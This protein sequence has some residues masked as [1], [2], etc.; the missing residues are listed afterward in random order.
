MN[1]TGRWWLKWGTGLAIAVLCSVTSLYLAVSSE[2]IAYRLYARIMM[3]LG[4]WRGNL[5]DDILP[6]PL[7]D[8]ARVLWVGVTLIGFILVL[9]LI[10]RAVRKIWSAR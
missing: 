3:R 7:T 4:M 5:F 8:F 9:L 1:D 10:L 6:P 2:D